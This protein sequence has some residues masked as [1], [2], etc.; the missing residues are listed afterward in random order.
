MY[1][2]DLNQTG[3]NKEPYE[4]GGYIMSRHTFK[5]LFLTIVTMLIVGIFLTGCNSDKTTTVKS[6]SDTTTT[7]PETTPT[8]VTPSESKEQSSVKLTL[9]F[10]NADASGLIA[11]DRTVIV[12]DQAVIQAMFTELATPPTGLE[13]PLP[14]GTSLLGATISAD[15]VATIDLSTDFQK[16]FNGGSAGEQM[17]MY[18]I[19]NTLTTLPNIHSVQ[20]L[21]D[22]KKHDGI[23]GHLDTS[24]P[25][26][27]NESM[28]AK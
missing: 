20:F 11:T 7:T 10:P 27:R 18:S 4:E 23:L 24:T 13:K 28:I 9:Y 14:Q 3:T 8:P 21:L 5:T 26:K 15:G 6:P 1:P 12:K 25:L 19:V 2:S 16:N 17:T 22:G